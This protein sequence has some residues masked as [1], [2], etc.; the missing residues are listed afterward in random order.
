MVLT[1]RARARLDYLDRKLVLE[2]APAR[3]R[4][5]DAPTLGRG[6]AVERALS[7]ASRALLGL[8]R[9]RL[10]PAGARLY[11][12]PY[13]LYTVEFSVRA[14]PLWR[15][16]T[17]TAALAVDG[18]N[19]HTT[20]ADRVPGWRWHDAGPGD[21]VKLFVDGRTADRLVDQELPRLAAVSLGGHVVRARRRGRLLVYKPIWAVVAREPSGRTAAVIVDA[22]TGGVGVVWYPRGRRLPEVFQGAAGGG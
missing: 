19:G 4:V 12:Y 17:H 22:I 9:R 3:V 6:A 15:L 2:H 14:L 8:R 11:Y 10:D 1:P 5:V 13:W 21:R 18:L 20:F 16:S 7:E